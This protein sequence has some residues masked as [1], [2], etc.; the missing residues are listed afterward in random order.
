MT[1]LD[2]MRALASEL[3]TNLSAEEMN[4][5]IMRYQKS[6]PVHSPA[7]GFQEA[8]RTKYFKQPSKTPEEHYKGKMEK[9]SERLREAVTLASKGMDPKTSSQLKWQG[10]T[11]PDSNNWAG[12][13]WDDWRHE[14]APK[15]ID[16]TPCFRCGIR[17]DIGCGC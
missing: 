2:R 17:A 9:A 5:I 1:E 11:G 6:L 13:E 4:A 16:R 14:E 12:G 3:G 7:L 10:R 15:P 8:E